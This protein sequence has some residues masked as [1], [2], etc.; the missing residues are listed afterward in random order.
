MLA[1]IASML[2]QT[3]P[4]LLFEG[5]V[6]RP[7]RLIHRYRYDFLPITRQCIRNVFQA[8][9]CTVIHQIFPKQQGRS[10]GPALDRNSRLGLLRACVVFG[11]DSLYGL[12][13]TKVVSKPLSPRRA[14]LITVLYHLLGV[15]A[16]QR[17]E[18]IV[19][20]TGEQGSG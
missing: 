2:L 9:E 10:A 15:S 4:D 12:D 18:Q 6:S 16:K 8:D 13:H 20:I 17:V 7:Q 5:F 3:L 14:P 11:R 19:C 1:A